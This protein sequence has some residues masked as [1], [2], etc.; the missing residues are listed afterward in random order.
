MFFMT[1]NVNLNQC[2]ALP[3][4]VLPIIFK[5]LSLE[6]D[7]VALVCKEWQAA[8]DSQTLRDIIRP[9]RVMGPKELKSIN[10]NVI[11]A[12]I[13]LPLPR[14][15]YRHFSE[16][17]GLLFFSP[18]KVKVKN[19][20]GEIE[21]V[22]LNSLGAIGN[23]FKTCF[24]EGSWEKAIHDEKIVEKPH[25]VWIDTEALGFNNTYA[26]QFDIAKKEDEKAYPER[27]KPTAKVSRH[28]TGEPKQIVSMVVVN[29]LALGMLMAYA[30]LEERHFIFDSNI[31]QYT[32]IRVKDTTKDY[33]GLEGQIVVGFAPS[34]LKVPRFDY[35]CKSVGFV[36]ARKS[37]GS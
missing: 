34:G 4:D 33:D 32:L 21:D 7:K 14:C 23:L 5:T 29:D 30:I 2:R 19:A 22:V 20:K 28:T 13:E 17:K 15:A 12:G 10:T 1:T 8:A 3:A 26:E 9:L 11:D 25:W 35:A 36:C 31:D 6:L 24:T 37:F 16:K 27:Y 18:G